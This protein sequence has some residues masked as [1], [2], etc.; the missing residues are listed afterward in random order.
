MK[1]F[2]FMWNNRS[3]V[4]ALTSQHLVL[5]LVSI[6]VAIVITA[7]EICAAKSFGTNHQKLRG[8]CVCHH[9]NG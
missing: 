4:L 9:S 1:A 7:G 8:R 5:V 6:G 2:E 3:Q